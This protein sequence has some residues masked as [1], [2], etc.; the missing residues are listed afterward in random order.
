M[1]VTLITW[2]YICFILLATGLVFYKLSNKLFYGRFNDNQPTLLVT[3]LNG[4]CFCLLIS[5]Y[6]YFFSNI[7][8]AIQ[9]V[10]LII[11]L[12]TLLLLKREWAITFRNIKQCITSIQY[13]KWGL[14]LLALISVLTATLGHPKNV[15]SGNYHVQQIQWM[16]KYS[17]VPGLGNLL[18]NYA[19]NQ[20]SFLVESLFSFSSI[21]DNPIRTL[22]GFLAFAVI[23]NA[24]M[25]L[26]IKNSKLNIIHAFTI[27]FFFV[28]YRNWLS[29]PSPD[30]VI[31]LIVYSVFFLSIRKINESKSTDV[32]FTLVSI[33]F[34]ALSAVTIK[35]SAALLPLVV[36]LF[37][38]LSR[39]NSIIRRFTGIAFLF[40]L[41]I[42]TPWLARSVI[43]SG[44]LIFPVAELDLFQVDWKIPTVV[45]HAVKDAIL[46]FSIN[47]ELPTQDII[48]LSYI[49]RLSVWYNHNSIVDILLLFTVLLIQL[50][51]VIKLANNRVKNTQ[52]K[53]L[54]FVGFVIFVNL[55][56]WFVNAPDFRFGSPYLY[57]FLAISLLIYLPSKIID[58]KAVSIGLI[59]ISTVGLIRK[60]QIDQL[61]EYPLYAAEYKKPN[62]NYSEGI[63]FKAAVPQIGISCWNHPLPCIPFGNVKHI[64]LRG[65]DLQSG[66]RFKYPEKRKN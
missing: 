9:T 54:T 60:M 13:W 55:V 6:V 29:S 31:A 36:L 4:Y 53:E 64:E 52:Q 65:T 37:M 22:N 63:G 8:I 7:G 57:L 50:V 17:I 28:Y 14:L 45:V 48:S 39:N 12:S 35:L 42:L 5:S 1:L 34:I 61:M 2:V 18:F 43:Y 44:Y 41:L 51:F 25:G 19:Y 33:L 38:I 27:V 15:D 21:F 24:I 20:S 62:V 59:V 49:E 11:A 23:S 3:I 30:I 56:F 58:S 66:F 26:N 46:A 32:D 47:P 10:L 16:S 40:G